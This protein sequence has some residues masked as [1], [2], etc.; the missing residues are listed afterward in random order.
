M[1]FDEETMKDVIIIPFHFKSILLYH[2]LSAKGINVV[3]FWD[4]DKSLNGKVYENINITLPVSIEAMYEDVTVLIFYEKYEKEIAS[5]IRD[6]GYSDV[7]SAYS[8]DMN[9]IYD[10]TNQINEKD[11]NKINPRYLHRQ[12]YLK[13]KEYPLETLSADSIIN[14]IENVN[15]P[16]VKE[17]SRKVLLLSHDIGFSGAPIALYNAARAIMSNG[18]IPIICCRSFGTLLPK[19]LNAEIPVIIDYKLIESDLFLPLVALCDIVIV[20]TFT[21]VSFVAIEKLNGLSVPVLW[22][23]HEGNYINSRNLLENSPYPLSKNIHVYCVSEYARNHL[24]YAR[25]D[26]AAKLL[27]YGID[28]DYIAHKNK[29]DRRLKIMTVGLIDKGK[30]Q[31]L[32]CEAIRK[33]KKSMRE[34]CEFIFVGKSLASDPIYKTVLSLKND[35]PDDIIL[36]GEMEPSEIRKMLQQCDC[37]VCASRDDS[38]PMFIAEAMMFHIVCICS[39]NT[40]FVD[41]IEDGVNGFIY[42]RNCSAELCSKIDYFIRNSSSLDEM[43][44]KSRQI[45][46]D[47][48]T[49]SDFRRNLLEILETI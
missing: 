11:L 30:G 39:E 17:C 18:D 33:L 36:T 19:I 28:D 14:V 35:F 8:L 31:D 26:I 22:W 4:N 49:F 5:Q 40:G 21:L 13:S 6:L 29:K 32:L 44:Q 20:N 9:R 43:R 27:V 25:P 42:N 15:L 45:Y 38:M 46:E 10:Y 16:E 24:I 1:Y 3:G 34:K 37:M 41:L 23:T 7:I 2:M 47:H 12:L 48:F